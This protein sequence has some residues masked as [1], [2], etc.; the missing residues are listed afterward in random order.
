M[1]PAHYVYT[2]GFLNNVLAVYDKCLAFYDN[3]IAPHLSSLSGSVMSMGSAF[4]VFTAN[5]TISPAI[6]H[7][8][9]AIQII[10]IGKSPFLMGHILPYRVEVSWEAFS[11]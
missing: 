10:V 11:L 1:I 7:T 8:A 4:S 2:E 3:H 5:S 6:D 9:I